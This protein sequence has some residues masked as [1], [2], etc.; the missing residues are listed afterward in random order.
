MQQVRPDCVSASLD[1]EVGMEIELV[2]SC[3]VVFAKSER[4]VGEVHG[5]GLEHDL[6]PKYDC[7]IVSRDSAASEESFKLRNCGWETVH[8]LTTWG[9]VESTKDVDVDSDF[10]TKDKGED[11]NDQ[12]WW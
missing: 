5:I 7:G 9:S 4:Q 1:A 2:Y 3:A 10:V 6:L 8:E 11:V 12:V